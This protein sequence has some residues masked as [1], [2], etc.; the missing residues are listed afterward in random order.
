MEQKSAALERESF[1]AM[2]E[3]S[4]LYGWS[5]TKKDEDQN[6]RRSI[7][8]MGHR[9]GKFSDECKTALF[10]GDFRAVRHH[11]FERWSG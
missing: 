5:L 8:C 1:E 11:I 4:L 9:V 6:H 7:Q 2:L 10:L 3:V